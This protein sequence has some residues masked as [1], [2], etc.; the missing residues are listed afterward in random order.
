MKILYTHDAKKEIMVDDEDYIRLLKYSWRE[1]SNGIIETG[2]THEVIANIVMQDY[3]HMYDHRDRN[4][5]N[6]QKENL[7]IATRSQNGAN[8]VKFKGKSSKYKGVSFHKGECRWY[9]YIRINYKLIHLG[10][11]ES[12]IAAAKC[13]NIHARHHFGEFAVINRI[14]ENAS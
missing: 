9:A 10:K 11:F 5:L 3:S 2:H 8:R 6:N 13:Y 4:P 12:E 1:S 7:R 14:D